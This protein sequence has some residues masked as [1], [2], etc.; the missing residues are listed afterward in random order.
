MAGTAF[1]KGFRIDKVSGGLDGLQYVFDATYKNLIG[2]ERLTK[3]DRDNFYL[4][5]TEFKEG[6]FLA[7][8][9]AIYSGIQGALPFANYIAADPESLWQ[10]TQNTHKFLKEIFTSAHEGR[11]MR[12]EN[13]TNGTAVIY[14]DNR[15][16]TFNGPVYN[17]GKSAISGYRTLDDMLDG[18]IVKK[19]ELG[20]DDKPSIEMHSNEKGLFKAPIKVDEQPHKLECDVFDFNKYEKSG[21]VKIYP[22]QT[23]EEGCYKFRNIG[24]ES[25]E[26]YILSM[27]E[28]S[29]AINCLVEYVNDPLTESNIGSL[30]I[31]NVAA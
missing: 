11:S 4:Q 8:F 15:N 17:I 5:A 23:V 10:L 18:D 2:K 6:S 27:T 30:L 26:D 31:I 19:I 7:Y 3:K 22:N 20:Q 25:V 21:K 14:D 16:I 24:G 1:D 9:D 29:V 13:N 28:Q 12:I